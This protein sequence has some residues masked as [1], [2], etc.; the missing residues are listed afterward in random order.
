MVRRSLVAVEIKPFSHGYP[1]R[2]KD[3]PNK[4]ECLAAYKAL[5]F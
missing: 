2:F 1:S 4:T 3:F 5:D